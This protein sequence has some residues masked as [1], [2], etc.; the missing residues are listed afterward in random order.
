MTYQQWVLFAK[1]LDVVRNMAVKLDELTCNGE[2]K[3]QINAIQ[4][5]MLLFVTDFK[6]KLA[7][8]VDQETVRN[9]VIPLVFFLDE[10]LIKQYFKGRIGQWPLLQQSVCKT[11]NGGRLFYRSLDKSL[12]HGKQHKFV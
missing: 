11:T 5:K 2:Q 4:Q 9:T 7:A 3:E 1:L 8:Q 6:N 12:S 10:W